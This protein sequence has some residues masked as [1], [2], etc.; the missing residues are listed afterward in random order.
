LLPYL[1]KTLL[2]FSILKHDV[3]FGHF[4]MFF[5]KINVLQNSSIFYN[6]IIF[7]ENEI[8][9]IEFI[10]IKKNL[11]FLLAIINFWLQFVFLHILI[12]MQN[13]F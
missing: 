1:F 6:S 12:G 10:I 8:Y 7:S 9:S 2:L 13:N 5:N 11:Y 3:I 4:K